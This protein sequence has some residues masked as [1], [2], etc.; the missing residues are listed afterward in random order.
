M[1]RY[2]VYF[3][4]PPSSALHAFGS[5][6]LG[7]DA[8]SGVACE[9]P[10]VPGVTPARLAAITGSPR[11]Y[12]LHATLKA[13]MTL[14]AGR[15]AAELDDAVRQ[16]AGRLAPFSFGIELASLGGFL[17]LVPRAIDPNIAALERACVTELDRFRAPPTAA[18]L[19]RRLASGLSPEEAANLEQWGY[20]YVLD[21]FRFHITLTERLSD[22][23]RAVVQP[24]LAA[25]AAPLT[26]APLELD[27]LL[28]FEQAEG[29]APFT[30]RSRHLLGGGR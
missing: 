9:Q 19:E 24:L 10:A 22:A 4:P 16:L 8:Y 18:E 15:E 30:V 1:R 6:W 26:Q 14:A 13:P 17:A 21:R 23:E 5:A 7:R 3:A 20:P 12:G 2:A 25:L 29:A 27:A 11:L 28:V